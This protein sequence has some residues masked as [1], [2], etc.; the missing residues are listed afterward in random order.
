[1]SLWVSLVYWL[2]IPAFQHDGTTLATPRF[3]LL[4][5]LDVYFLVT[6]IC[7]FEQLHS[8]SRPTSGRTHPDVGTLGATRLLIVELCG[9]RIAVKLRQI[10]EIVQRKC[11]L[12]IEPIGLL[13]ILTS[14][15]PIV[16]VDGSN[17]A[18][19]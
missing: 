7:H 12:G 4:G 18:Q 11:V 6:V 9:F 1:R 3:T 5:Y 10:T 16:P 19:V 15:L 17:A 14:I 8:L 2:A 13:K